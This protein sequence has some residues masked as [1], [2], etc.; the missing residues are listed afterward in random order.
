[1]RR[2]NRF[3][4]TLIGCCLLLAGTL[5]AFAQDNSYTVVRGDTLDKIGATYDVQ[6][7]CLAKAN[8]IGLGDILLPG[9]VIAIS[10]DCPRYDGVDNVIT[11]RQVNQNISENLGQGGGGGATSTPY[12]VQRGDSLD[13]IGQ[14]LN[15]S[16]VALIQA[17]GLEGKTVLQPG[18]EITI[19]ANAPAYGQV[20]AAVN[21]TDAGQGG[22]GGAP[23]AAATTSAPDLSD[24]D[25]TYV[26]QYQDTLDSIG[27]QYDVKVACLVSENDLEDPMWIYPGQVLTVKT[28]C[29]RYDGFD[30][31]VNP[32]NS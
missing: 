23:T 18:Q 9:Q 25:A 12:Q 1:M 13:S 30:I 5:R 29:P 4:P 7:A 10:F 17:N 2:L 20:P 16:V 19:P 22:G 32:R 26:V 3:I 28:S 6:V 14:A 21:S 15:V 11:P 8:N 24:G 31:V 27:A